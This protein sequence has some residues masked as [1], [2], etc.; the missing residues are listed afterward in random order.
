MFYFMFYESVFLRYFIPGLAASLLFLGISEIIL[1]KK[2]ERISW[3]R[4]I[5]VLAMGLYLTVVFSVTVS[6][7]YVFSLENFG[8][9]I[10]VV[11]F[12]VLHKDFESWGNMI[13]FIPFGTLLV[14]LSKKCQKLYVTLLAGAGLSLFIELLQLF[15]VRITDIDDLI[16]NTAGTLCGFILGKLILLLIPSL[17]KMVGIIKIEDGKLYKKNND[18]GSIVIL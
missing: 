2:N 16:L 9:N 8:Q 1:R 5:M 11:P 7:D 17:R 13:M 14:L 12:R 6:V 15:S 10:N 18:A 4:R 3:F